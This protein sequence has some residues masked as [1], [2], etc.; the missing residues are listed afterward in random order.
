MEITRDLNFFGRLCAALF[1]AVDNVRI[2]RLGYVITGMIVLLV[3]GAVFATAVTFHSVYKIDEVWRGFDTGLGRRLDL[4]GNLE[5][6][7]GR[8]GLTSRAAV[9]Q[10]GGAAAVRDDLTQLREVFPAY[11]MARPT[12]EES[13]ALERIGGLVA[14]YEAGAPVAAED[15]TRALD[16]LREI[17]RR[18]RLAGADQVDDAIWTL[19]AVIAA[20]MI[21]IGAF[22]LLLGLFFY[23]FL[24][25]RLSV[26]LDRMRTVMKG[27]ASGD[28]RIEV[29]YLD[30][31]DEVGDMAR[32]VQVFKE[33]AQDKNRM[34]GRKADLIHAVRENL[35]GLSRNVSGTMRRQAAAAVKMSE[36]TEHLALSIGRVEEIARSAQDST[37][38]TSEAVETGRKTVQE[39]IEAMQRTA[40]SIVNAVGQLETLKQRSEEIQ[41]IVET[42]QEISEQTNLLALNAAIE[43][44]R[45]GDA[46]RGFAVVADEVKK[47]ANQVNNS[48]SGITAILGALQQQV[49]VVSKD[50]HAAADE[51]THSAD[52]SA[53]VRQSL[54][55]IEQRAEHVTQ[56]VADIAVAAREQSASG[57]EISKQV[58][59]VAAMAEGTQKE[60]GTVVDELSRNLNAAVEAL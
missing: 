44:A 19:S 46:G 38:E 22:L 57:A 4:L 18:Q 25:F 37:R 24:R 14:R 23:W 17:T 39:T 43:S 52:R 2:S 1:S 9:G 3:V 28:I 10:D 32:A 6:F 7:M 50:V 15:G 51:A 34:E 13:E 8:A 30:K 21:T 31:R 55:A 53:E 41:T 49:L 33:N 45:A 36:A 5:Y 54:V 56:A 42:I 11:R 27:L 59:A 20:L 35:E 48:A 60:V 58:Q 29:Q 12:P 16:R 47:L 40:G 26:P